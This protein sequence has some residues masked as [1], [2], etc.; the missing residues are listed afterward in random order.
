MSKAIQRAQRIWRR[1]VVG[2]GLPGLVDRT[3]IRSRVRAEPGERTTHLLLAAPGGGNVGDQAMLEAVLENTA[4]PVTLVVPDRASVE[5]PEEFRQRVEV[6]EIPH[7][8]Y[9]TG[10]DHRASVA[11]FGRALA[12]AAHLSVL[13]ADV[14]DGRYSLPASVRRSTLARAAARA[15]VETRVIGF[16]WSD[17]ARVAARRSLAAAA[18]DGV[19]LLLRDPISAGR[20]R[21]DGIAPVEEVA[22]VVFA[23]RSV[24][25]SAADQLL[26][27]VTKPVALVNVSGLLADRMD[28]TEEYVRIVAALRERGLHVLVLPHVDRAQAGDMAA[29]AALMARVGELADVSGVPS[30]LSPAQVRGLTARASIAVTGRMHL[31]VMSFLNGV[32]AITLAS[33][34]KVEGLM[35]LFGTP[36]L[37]IDAAPGFAAEVVEVVDRVLPADSAARES[38]RQALPGVV[39]MARRNTADLSAPVTT[40]QA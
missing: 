4:G 25:G 27:D 23:A 32:P 26:Q 30:I 19:R 31:A 16:S 21:R 36:E 8:V 18:R 34:G 13:G 15:G 38:I 22:D 28:Q 20:A 12:G 33:Q 37:R 24:D 6:L 1:A 7:L 40:G 35:Q 10:A 9:G 11:S 14:M 3:I 2:S 5:L 17:R 39:A 29:C